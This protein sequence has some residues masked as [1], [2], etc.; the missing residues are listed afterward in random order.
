MHDEASR[1]DARIGPVDWREFPAGSELWTFEAPSGGLAAVSI[2]P[3]DGEPVVLL[4]GVTG[5]KEDF[6]LM[7]PVIAESGYRVH[8]LDLAG[9]YESWQAGP[10]ENGEYSWQLYLDDTIAFL[11]HVGA[12]HLLGYSFAGHVAQQVALQRPELVRSLGLLCSPPAVGNSFRRIK[13]VGW[14]STFSSAV[15]GASLMIW[16]IRGNLNGVDESRLQ[17]VRS[18][19]AFTI[20]ESVDDI[21]GLMMD[22][23]DVV[24]GVRALPVPKLVVVGEHDL[25]TVEDHRAYARRIGADIVVY[26]T[27]HSPCETTPNQLSRDLVALYRKASA[28]A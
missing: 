6:L 17:F 28:E 13:R 14:I 19:F 27:G 1:A 3:L 20:R 25:W 21:V 10:D 5:S 26:R 8:S 22:V 12:A 2:G 16:G 18:R 23:P 7:L 15:V 4:P 11:E 24:A 9:Q